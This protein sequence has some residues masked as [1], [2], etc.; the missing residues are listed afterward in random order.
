[1]PWPSSGCGSA[2]RS[3]VGDGAGG[4]DSLGGGAH[5]SRRLDVRVTEVAN[6]P[7]Y[8]HES[9]SFKRWR[10]RPGRTGGR[11][12]HRAGGRHRHPLAGR[13]LR[14]PMARREGDP[15]A[16]RTPSPRRSCTKQSRR[17]WTPQARPLATTDEVCRVIASADLTLVLHEDASDGSTSRPT[18]EA[19]RIIVVVGPEGGHQRRSHR[20][21]RSRRDAGAA[22]GPV[23]SGPRAQGQPLWL[24]SRRGC[25]G[26]AQSGRR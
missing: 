13:T 19:G 24:C 14:L 11:D 21:D 20:F 3:T 7:A 5:Y 23:S 4:A 17:W 8:R 6:A 22:G 2:S 26:P 18:P 9:R 25:G 12:G 1:M 15:R 10:R 16:R